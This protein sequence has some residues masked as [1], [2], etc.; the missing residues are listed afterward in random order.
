MSRDI[1]RNLEKLISD[2][3]PDDVCN[4]YDTV[5]RLWHMMIRLKLEDPLNYINP[6]DMQFLLDE[7]SDYV[8]RFRNQRSMSGFSPM[9][10]EEIDSDE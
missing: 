2:I 1:S 6:Y 9:G 7:I 3:D 4:D 8:Q 5:A 10:F